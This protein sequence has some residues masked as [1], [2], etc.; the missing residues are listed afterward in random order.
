MVSKGTDYVR[1]D[2]VYDGITGTLKST[3][4]SRSGE[5]KR[6]WISGFARAHLSDA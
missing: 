3:L 2:V 4:R 6:V 1:G 5:H